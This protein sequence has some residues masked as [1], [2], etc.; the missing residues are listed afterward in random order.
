VVGA[1]NAFPKVVRTALL[2]LGELPPTFFVEL[3]RKRF[4]GECLPRE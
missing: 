2:L 4:V 1:P 3:Q